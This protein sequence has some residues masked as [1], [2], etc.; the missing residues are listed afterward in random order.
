M[1]RSIFISVLFFCV[2]TC[3]AQSDTLFTNKSKKIPCKIYEINEF[4]IR[5]RMAG[6]IDGPLYIIDKSTITK[7]TLSNGYTEIL[8]PDELSL[9]NEHKEIIGN[10]EVIKINPFGFAFNHVTVSYEKVLKVGMNLDVEL[11]YINNSINNNDIFNQNFNG[12]GSPFLTGAYLKPGV[13]F[14]LG[15][16]FS[17]RGLK[18][19]HP[20]KGRYIKLDLAGSYLNYQNVQLT[21]YNTVYNPYTTVTTTVVSTDVNAVAYGGFV[22]FGRQF[23]LGN[24]LTLEYYFGI[25]FTAQSISYSNP[26]VKSLQNPSYGYQD[27]SNRLGNYYGFGRIPGIGLSGTCGFRIGYI[28]PSKKSYRP[29]QAVRQS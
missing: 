26:E 18:Y 17:V 20:L 6:A 14:F 29:A 21:A 3:F 22:N 27:F 5:Y 4:E 8:L 19:A 1:K 13:K 15:Q 28:I 25:G 10:R 9:E 12:N 24:I 2:V 7:Y 16:D 23:I 11:G